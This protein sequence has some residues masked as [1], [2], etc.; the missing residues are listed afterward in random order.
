MCRRAHFAVSDRTTVPTS[1]K[2]HQNESKWRS[3]KTLIVG[4]VSELQE[5]ARSEVVVGEVG[6]VTFE[7]LAAMSF[8]IHVAKHWI[9]FES[10]TKC[11][12]ANEIVKWTN[13]KDCLLLSK[14]LSI[15]P[16]CFI[17]P[18]HFFVPLPHTLLKHF[19]LG[20]VFCT[21]RDKATPMALQRWHILLSSHL[22]G[23]DYAI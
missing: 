2:E 13:L 17:P 10:I 3:W 15:E 8:G 11:S 1:I 22:S 23:V 9:S 21:V 20:P 7:F 4:N 12:I 16:Y 19:D 6:T 5:E 18:P 14:G